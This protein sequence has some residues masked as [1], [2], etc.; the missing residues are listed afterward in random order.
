MIMVKYATT[1]QMTW[2]TME[3]KLGLVNG[4]LSENGGAFLS[5]V[6]QSYVTDCIRS[7]SPLVLNESRVHWFVERYLQLNKRGV[8]RWTISIG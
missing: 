5:R 1:L 6:A 3:D 4:P 7:D 8:C 2:T